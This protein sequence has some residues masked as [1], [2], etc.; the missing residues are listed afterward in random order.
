MR[1]VIGFRR[2]TSFCSRET[3]ETRREYTIETFAHF[4]QDLN[5]IL[6]RDNLILCCLILERFIYSDFITKD[7]LREGC[8]KLNKISVI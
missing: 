4:W 1:A 3:N 7:S 8:E 6:T 5:E 2:M